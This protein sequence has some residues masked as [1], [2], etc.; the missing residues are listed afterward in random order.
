[1]RKRNWPENHHINKKRPCTTTLKMNFSLLSSLFAL[2]LSFLLLFRLLCLSLS[3]SLSVSVCLC[4]SPW[5]CVLCCGVVCAVLWCGVKR[6]KTPCVHSK[7]SRVYV[8]NIPVCTFKTSPCMPAQRAHML[9]HVCAWC[10]YTL[11]R[12]ERTHGD[13]LNGHKGVFSLV[14]QE[15][16]DMCFCILTG[17]W[18]H[19]LSPNFGLPKFPT[20][21]YQVLQRFTRSNPLDLT[22]FK[23]E[24]TKDKDTST[25]PHHTTPH[26]TPPT[27][28]PHN[29]KKQRH[30]RTRTCVCTWICK[31]MCTCMC[32]YIYTHE[33]KT[34]LPLMCTIP[35]LWPS[36]MVEYLLPNNKVYIWQTARAKTAYI[37]K[38]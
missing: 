23:F 13:V 10:R 31:C 11:G 34:Y 35:S 36:T 19:L 6:W 18:C 4:L 25:S 16:F 28:A 3:L 29:K 7:H 21:G 9:K 12:F 20:W 37:K 32:V 14:K 24:N 27:T 2:L 22:N 30:T 15:F 26:T 33:W 1:M 8:Q 38:Y 17:C 5:C